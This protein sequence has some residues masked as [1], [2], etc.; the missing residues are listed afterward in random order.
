MRISPTMDR[1]LIFDSSLEHEV[2]P[3]FHTRYAVSAWLHDQPQ[4][5][6]QPQPQTQTQPQQQG[7]D[8]MFVA[9]LPESVQLKILSRCKLAF[10]LRPRGKTS[11]K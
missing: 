11:W 5:Q 4:P 10:A 1:L 8:L 9:G 3:A 6:P 2:L 7:R